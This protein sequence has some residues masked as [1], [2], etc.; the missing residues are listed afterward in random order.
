MTTNVIDLVPRP[1]P[2]VTGTVSDGQPG[3]D[4]LLA[5][6]REQGALRFQSRQTDAGS[7]FI[8][9]HESAGDVLRWLMREGF[10]VS[11]SRELNGF[12]A[13]KLEPPGA[14]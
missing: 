10:L 9:P 2:P 1:A 5:T 11:N 8:V 12:V 6:A 14:A 7:V 4:R 3:L 13:K